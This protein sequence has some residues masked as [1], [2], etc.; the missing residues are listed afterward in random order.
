MTF[1]RIR[2]LTFIFV[3]LS[4]SLPAHATGG[5][6]C[7]V[8]DKNVKLHTGAGMQR[9]GANSLLNPETDL[10]IFLPGTPPDF[11]KLHLKGDA[12]TQHW[13]DDKDFKLRLYTERET[14]LF[15]SVELLILAKRVDEGEYAGRYD[16]R[17]EHMQSEKDSEAKTIKAR[18]KI[19]CSVE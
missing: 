2:S 10:E 11:R 6:W 15:G 1:K 19:K 13:I 12:I 16:L 14:G 5:F 18:G 8:A 4:T 9:G 17:V 7:D 3:T